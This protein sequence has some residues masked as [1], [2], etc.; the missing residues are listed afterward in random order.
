MLAPA[1]RGAAY[2]QP[3]QAERPRLAVAWMGALA[4]PIAWIYEGARAEQDSDP[5]AALGV[6]EGL[7]MAMDQ[8]SIFDLDSGASVSN[9]ASP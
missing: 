5:H 3:G 1:S 4:L 7:F 2:P 6:S 8:R 9:R